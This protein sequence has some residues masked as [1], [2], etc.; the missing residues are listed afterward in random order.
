MLILGIPKEI[1]P[2]EG[3]VVLV[4]AAVSEIIHRGGRV[5]IEKHAGLLSGYDDQ[6]YM[7]V[8]AIICDSA[9]MLYQQSEL[10]VKVKEPVAADLKYLR[11]DHLLFC[12]LHLAANVDLLDALVKKGLLAIG[13]ETVD[14]QGALPLLAPMSEVAGRVAVQS[15]AHALHAPMG[16]RGVLLG[17]ATAT[18]RGNVTV[19]GAGTAGTFAIM[20][21]AALGANVTVFDIDPVSLKKTRA[22][23]PNIT[24]LYPSRHAIQCALET[25]D[26]LIGAVLIPG[27][28]APKLVTREMVRSM[29]NGSVI[30]DISIDQGGCIETMRPTDYRDPTFV[31]EGV[32]HMGVTNLPG[33]V[34]RTASD[35]LSAAVLPYALILFAGG[36]GQC[37]PL[38]KGINVEAGKVIHPALVSL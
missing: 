31:D 13:F 34:P 15:G 23:S 6:S 4:P 24:A 27:A 22:L 35:A 10:I 5:Y 7:D 21:A 18:H 26:L 14:K 36:L 20:E 3:R 30:V 19:L 9:E 12:Y 38:V 25:T 33:A 37:E 28:A 11:S 17:G 1:K 16:G 2:L 29:P 32:L 8:G